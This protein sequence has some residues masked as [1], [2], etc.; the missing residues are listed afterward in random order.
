[1]PGAAVAAA[2]GCGQPLLRPPAPPP[3]PSVSIP[4]CTRPD[5]EMCCYRTKNSGGG[6]ARKHER[7]RGGYRGGNLA[8][9]PGYGNVGTWIGYGNTWGCS[10]R[11]CGDTAKGPGPSGAG[12]LPK[13]CLQKHLNCP[14]WRSCIQWIMGSYGDDCIGPIRQ[15]SG[16]WTVT[17][18]V[19]TTRHHKDATLRLLG[20]QTAGKKTTKA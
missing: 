3:A 9:S 11:I 16:P 7:R 14:G 19:G 15:I 12:L 2:R 1:M 4:R 20:L 17:D 10:V 8:M 5:G 18:L 13:T 6:G